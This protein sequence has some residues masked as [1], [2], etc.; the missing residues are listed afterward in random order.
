MTNTAATTVPRLRKGATVRTFG[1][2][3]EAHNGASARYVGRFG[4]ILRF[5]RSDV[6]QTFGITVDQLASGQVRIEK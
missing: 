6:A 5:E 4:D 2:F 3:G 1:A